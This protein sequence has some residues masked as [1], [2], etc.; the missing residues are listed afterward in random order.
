MNGQHLNWYI[1]EQLPMIRPERFEGKLGKRKIADFVRSEVL[2]L[3][4]T[5]WDLQPFARDLGYEGAP[6][7]WDEEDRRQ[8]MHAI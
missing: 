3:S 1:V 8:W 4:Y 7:E 6:F 2:R 5:A